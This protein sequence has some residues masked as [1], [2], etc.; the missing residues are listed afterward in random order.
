M[1]RSVYDMVVY[2]KS[3]IFMSHIVTNVSFE[4]LL[5]LHVRFVAITGNCVTLR[6]SKNVKIY[7]SQ[8]T[9]PLVH[10]IYAHI[11]LQSP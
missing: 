3:S 7:E 2:H 4:D 1:Y 11:Q 10:K 6:I 5:R 9:R 8:C